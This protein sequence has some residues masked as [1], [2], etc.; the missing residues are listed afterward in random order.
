MF[1]LGND[2]PGLH[3]TIMLTATIVL[4]LWFNYMIFELLTL[5]RIRRKVLSETEQPLLLEGVSSYIDDFTILTREHIN[6]LLLLHRTV[7]PVIVPTIESFVSI[8]RYS[9]ILR[10]ATGVACVE[11][12]YEVD[13]PCRLQLLWGVDVTDARQAVAGNHSGFNSWGRLESTGDVH[14]VDSSS[15]NNLLGEGGLLQRTFAKVGVVSPTSPNGG[16]GG[17]GGGASASNKPPHPSAY[18][19][20]NDLAVSLLPAGDHSL[21]SSVTQNENIVEEVL[22]ATLQEGACPLKCVF[23]CVCV[24]LCVCVR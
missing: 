8:D 21:R 1:E 5:V 17:T 2:Q 22:E 24:C 14:P 13:I 15:K 12:K 7:P 11:L 20:D 19:H 18:S 3:N 9:L 6:Q 10:D 16:G 4:M 23:N